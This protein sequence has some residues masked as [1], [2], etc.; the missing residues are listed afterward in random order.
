MILIDTSAWIEFLRDTRSA[1]CQAVSDCITASTAT[2]DPIRMEL[3]AG[4]RDDRHLHSLRRLIARST[5]LRLEPQDYE[6]AAAI[7]RVCRRS[8]ET[9][10]RL[11]DC[12]IASVSL[13][14]DTPILHCDGDFDAIARHTG[15]LI[16]SSRLHN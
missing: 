10:R 12:L 2:C 9:V 16:E 14:T 6:E 13:R 15:L 4:A 1:T 8:G 11:I 7:Y 3:L 5:S